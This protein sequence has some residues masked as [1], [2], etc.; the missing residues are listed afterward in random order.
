MQR[1]FDLID[2]GRSERADPDSLSRATAVAIGGGILARIYAAV[3]GGTLEL[4]EETVPQL[5]Y[6]AVL[7]YLG[8]EAAQRELDIRPP[9]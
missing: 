3:E 2:E 9:A 1:L 6:A 5:M 4:G 7:P 8:P